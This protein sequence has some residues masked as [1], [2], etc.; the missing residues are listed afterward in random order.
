MSSERALR[1][2]NGLGAR[3]LGLTR[4][5]NGLGARGSGQTLAARSAACIHFGRYPDVDV[6]CDTR[7]S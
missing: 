5:A 2:E 4:A 3:G 7:S 1:A 6:G